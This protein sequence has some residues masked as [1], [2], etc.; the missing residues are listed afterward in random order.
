MLLHNATKKDIEEILNKEF[1][2]AFL[3]VIDDSAAHKGHAE[4]MLR[5]QAGHFKVVMVSQRFDNVMMVARHRMVYDKLSS[6]MDS[7]IHALSLN[8]KTVDE[9]KK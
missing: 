7:R 2:P 5:P 9:A 4:A 3:E 6:L 1:E 8:L